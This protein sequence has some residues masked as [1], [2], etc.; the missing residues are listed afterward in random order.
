MHGLVLEVAERH[1][2]DGLV[3][4]AVLESFLDE[5]RHL[6]ADQRAALASLSDHQSTVGRG[7]DA[8]GD[9]V[10]VHLERRR[11]ADDDLPDHDVDAHG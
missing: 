8:V 2:C 5:T 9:L 3:L 11:R 1:P 10:D 4:P 6:V 7:D